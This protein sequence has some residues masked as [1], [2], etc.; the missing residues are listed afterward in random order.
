M[1]EHYLLPEDV[2]PEYAKQVLDFLNQAR[3]A[4]VIAEAVEFPH[5]RDVGIRVAQ[6]I[7]NRRNELNGF[8]T[9][10]DLYAVPYVGPERFTE[11]V[12]SL[13]GARPPR[14]DSS[15]TPSELADLRRSIDALRA[16]LQPAVQ[17]RLWS[18]QETIWLGQNATVLV[19]L[20]DAGG[21]ALI[22]QPVTVTTSWGELSAPSGVEVISSNAVVT[23]TNDAGMAELRLRPRFQAPLAEAQRLALELAAG[24]LPLTAPWPTAASVQLSDL[25]ARY[26]G[27]GSDDLREAVDA[28]F[29]EYAASIEQAQ[30]RGEALAQWAQ[31]PVSIVCFVH[32]DGDERG[33][34]HLALATHTLIVRD[35]LPAFLVTFEHDAAV[36]KGLAGE[37]RR[38]PRDT[39]DP[40]VFL[41]DVFVSV[42]SFLNT[43][44]GG[45]GQA[46]RTR[47]A[48]DELRQFLQ[49]DV[50]GLPPQVKLTAAGGVLGA[51]R[52]IGEGGL[53]MF[54]AVD[55]TRRDSKLTFDATAGLLANRLST[56]ERT[57]V[58][59]Q[60]LEGVRTEILQQTHADLTTGIRDAQAA[61][62]TQIQQ[63][64]ASQ[65]SLSQQVTLIADAQTQ[66]SQ[67]ISLK[68]DLSA[69]S[70]LQ[71]QTDALRRDV[72]LKADRAA[73]DTLAR[74]SATLQRDLNALSAATTGLRS[75]VSGLSSSVEGLN[76][77][78]SRDLS[79]IGRRLSNIES[80]IGQR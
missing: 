11:I 12:V 40:N 9:L 13:S 42:Q 63:I 33:H 14:G 6:R 73:V 66:L 38:A 5:E 71:T 1:A 26:R 18:V 65:T 78:V 48:Q 57:A 72:D 60:Q 8:R 50:G 59:T 7:I 32:D 15:V 22:D 16:M 49:T 35:W 70:T 21:R 58:T 45:L 61:L 46:I 79:T 2:S 54:T 52:T 43:E 29:R 68:A 31:L 10:D 19:Q 56:L 47:A 27:P 80:R 67:Q 51:S 41:N 17:A 3:S 23:R 25:V 36:D 69:V 44:R 55:A 28:A 64:A 76:T 30:Y 75:D 62:A 4:R 39:T 53:T 37:L 20:N 24:Q 74:S 77:R 34:R